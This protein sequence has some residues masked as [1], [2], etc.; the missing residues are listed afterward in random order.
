MMPSAARQSALAVTEACAPLEEGIVNVEA[1]GPPHG[2]GLRTM[3]RATAVAVTN[4]D[5]NLPRP[6]ASAMGS[7]DE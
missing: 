1:I 3:T 6:G 2:A 5:R 7:H 4:G